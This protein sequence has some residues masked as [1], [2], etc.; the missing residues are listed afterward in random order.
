MLFS[1]NVCPIAINIS[2][3]YCLQALEFSADGL[4]DL[5]SRTEFHG[6]NQ[7]TPSVSQYRCRHG[8]HP[9][10]R[11]RQARV[12]AIGEKEQRERSKWIRMLDVGRRLHEATV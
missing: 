1:L 12:P 9:L 5:T 6:T 8:S 2:S 11:A 3:L 10:A 4:V 7:R